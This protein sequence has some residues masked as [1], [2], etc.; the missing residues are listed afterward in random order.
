ML[1][2]LIREISKN[3][4]LRLMM[5]ALVSLLVFTS[6]VAISTNH[7]Q[8]NMFIN[9]VKT[10]L[11]NIANDMEKFRS[12]SGGY[13][14]TLPNERFSYY[15][16]VHLNGGSS[17]SGVWYCIEATSIF[18]STIVFHIDSSDNQVQPKEGY[19]KKPIEKSQLILTPDGLSTAFVDSTSAKLTWNSVRF[20]NNYQVQCAKNSKFK[21]S[22]SLETKDNFVIYNELDSNARYS[23]RVKSVIDSEASDWSA[24][25]LIDTK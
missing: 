13:P 6:L 10:A 24:V 22:L 19:C 11:S 4:D 7:L 16:K 9:Q 2:Q 25:I 12:N 3:R 14:I 5:L 15:T 17:Q 21:N 20:A 1:K 8:K 18:D 23:C